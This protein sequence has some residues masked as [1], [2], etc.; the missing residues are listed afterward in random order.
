MEITVLKVIRVHDIMQLQEIKGIYNKNTNAAGLFLLFA[1]LAVGNVACVIR[2]CN[3]IDVAITIDVV[4]V[5]RYCLHGHMVNGS[6]PH[7]ME[8]HPSTYAQQIF[9]ISGIHGQFGGHISL[10]ATYMVMT[11]EVVL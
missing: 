3:V 5:F 2:S 8:I 6:E 11:C 1:D 9:P 7:G 4:L 10:S